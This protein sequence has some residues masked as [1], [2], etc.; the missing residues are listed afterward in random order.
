MKPALRRVRDNFWSRKLRFLIVQFMPL[1]LTKKSQILQT[2][3][4][5]NLTGLHTVTQ[6][7]SNHLCQECSVF[8]AATPSQPLRMCCMQAVLGFYLSF[9]PLRSLVSEAYL[10]KLIAL[11]I[12]GEVITEQSKLTQSYLAHGGQAQYHRYRPRR[13]A[14]ALRSSC[15][16]MAVIA[17]VLNTINFRASYQGR[18][19][20]EV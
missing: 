2:I 8:L 4:V 12:G 9:T 5:T 6:L 13:Y 16:M 17:R 3:S 19:R 15:L 14:K 10:L 7:S 18:G 20:S 1:L 11:V